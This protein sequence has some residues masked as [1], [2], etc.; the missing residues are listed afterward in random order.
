MRLKDLI[1]MCLFKRKH[2]KIRKQPYISSSTVVGKYKIGEF[3][4]FRY[5]DELY[6]GY[7]SYIYKREG[8][9]YYDIQVGG[10]CPAIIRGIKEET[11]F[12]LE[13]VKR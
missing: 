5:R 4:H 3:V 12:I 8:G 6:F 2:S 9:T 11:L 1:N 13:N 7:V 10:Q